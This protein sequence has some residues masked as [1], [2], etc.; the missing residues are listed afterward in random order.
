M[1]I[2]FRAQFGYAQ[3][4]YFPFGDVQLQICEYFQ[5]IARR[6]PRLIVSGALMSETKLPVPRM[7]HGAEMSTN[8]MRRDRRRPRSKMKDV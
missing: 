3:G 7:G 2:C 5:K 4:G 1:F 8:F 6:L